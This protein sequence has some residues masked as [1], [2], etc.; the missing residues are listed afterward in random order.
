RRRVVE[1]DEVID[2]P[3]PREDRGAGFLGVDRT[4]NAF[5]VPNARVGV[6]AD[7]EAVSLGTSFVEVLDVA[8]VQ[9]VEAAVGK[10]DPLT[11]AAAGF[12]FGKQLRQ[13]PDLAGG[14][15]GVGG[16]GRVEEV[17]DNLFAGH[18]RDA[19]LLDFQS[20]GHIRQPNRGRVV[21]TCGQCEPEDTHDHVAGAGNVVDLS[22]PRWVDVLGP[23][24]VGEGHA[25]LI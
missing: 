15:V 21:G 10:G 16:G 2:R 19:D 8:G 1:K 14:G 7:Y 20:A 3:E 25:V 4:S 9:D 5:E 13:R 6:Q 12:Q 24:A 18:G 23:V 22:R 11:G 17:V